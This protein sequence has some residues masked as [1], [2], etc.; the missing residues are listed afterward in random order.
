[1][2]HCPNPDC[3]HL[4]ETGRAGEFRDSI[5]KCS[6]C[7]AVLAGG[8]P[9][10]VEPGRL[11]WSRVEVPAD[12]HL[13]RQARAA[14]ET[15]G[16]PSVTQKAGKT[17]HMLGGEAL[18]MELF[19]PEHLAQEAAV[20][21]ERALH[22][23]VPLPDDDDLEFVGEDDAPISAEADAGDPGCPRCAADSVTRAPEPVA[24]R[25]GLLSRLLR[26]G[27]DWQCLACGHRW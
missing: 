14:L 22:A 19:V 8:P 26:P 13:L 10:E 5:E 1:V 24:E 27:R 23:P 17:G 18:A 3:V 2:K 11:A 6:D 16:I 7:G 15:A 12:P 21:L 9:P 25:R 20:T 4:A